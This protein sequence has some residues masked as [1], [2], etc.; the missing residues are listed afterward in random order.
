M[1]QQLGPVSERSRSTPHRQHCLPVMAHIG[2]S[3]RTRRVDGGPSVDRASL[4]SLSAS[5]GP[6]A[7]SPVPP[8]RRSPWRVPAGTSWWAS[9]GRACAHALAAT[10][11]G[12]APAVI[13]RR[14]IAASPR[15]ASVWVSCVCRHTLSC[16]HHRAAC[17]I[18]ITIVAL[19]AFA[20][21]GVGH[22]GGKEAGGPP[23]RVPPSGFGRR[24][25][26]STSRGGERRRTAPPLAVLFRFACGSAS[27]SQ[28]N[29]LGKTSRD[30]T[31]VG[32]TNMTLQAPQGRFVRKH[33][34]LRRPTDRGWSVG[35]AVRPHPFTV[36]G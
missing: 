8:L 5:R 35:V 29:M 26:T 28:S 33:A 6:S 31:G 36:R 1:S 27:S 16:I 18:I 21:L 4:L 23:S 13:D 12:R 11:H 19:F 32:R 10:A 34:L 30:R 15:R 7:G 9:R 14:T 2:T 22:G 20:V 17:S 3:V 24:S 25:L